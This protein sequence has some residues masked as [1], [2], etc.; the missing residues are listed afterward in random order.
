M[1]KNLKVLGRLSADLQ[2]TTA[3]RRRT[4]SVNGIQ[5]KGRALTEAR[6]ETWQFLGN[7]K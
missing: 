1:K 3:V 7:S 4:F 5:A 6:M 2:I